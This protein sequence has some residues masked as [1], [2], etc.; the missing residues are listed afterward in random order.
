MPA[1]TT[2]VPELRPLDEQ[3]GEFNKTA[4]GD[5]GRIARE[6]YDTIAPIVLQDINAVGEGFNRQQFNLTELQEYCEEWYAGIYR[7]GLFPDTPTM[8]NGLAQV[9][10]VRGLI[11]H[12]WF[13]MISD[14]HADGVLSEMPAPSGWE[15]GGEAEK[16]WLEYTPMAR[17]ALRRAAH[18]WSVHNYAVITAEPRLM[19]AISPTSYYRVGLPEQR[20]ADVGHVLMLPYRDLTLAELQQNQDTGYYNAIEIVKAYPKDDMGGADGS[21]VQR[22]TRQRFEYNDTQIG[23]PMDDETDSSITAIFTLGEGHSWYFAAAPLVA[24][25]MIAESMYNIELNIH[26]NRPLVIP[27]S[28]YAS[29]LG[30][31][32]AGAG[33]NLNDP[34]VRRKVNEYLNNEYKPTVPIDPDDMGSG[35]LRDYAPQTDRAMQM[36]GLADSIALIGRLT[37]SAFGMNVGKGESGAA[38]EKAEDAARVAMSRFREQVKAN[39]PRIVSEMGCPGDAGEL[40]F[41]WDRQPLTSSEGYNEQTLQL[42]DAG[43]LKHNEAR[44]R[45][46]LAPDKDKD[47][48]Y[49]GDGE[50]DPMMMNGGGNG[51]WMGNMPRQ[52]EQGNDGDRD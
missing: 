15:E 33:K 34:D 47:G 29:M 13:R 35:E 26:T 1:T 24:A 21:D 7:R 51:D 30:A 22:V 9:N 42:Y 11:P 8:Q 43:L 40:N 4:F 14:W 20:D 25:Y 2:D 49:K 44:M 31:A 39:L 27:A 19:R 38:R 12:N 3:D 37:P 6:A 50:P 23:R 52:E 32:A 48:E 10:R 16:W 46:G 36:E 45:L 18:Y 28:A 41:D 5:E 17:T